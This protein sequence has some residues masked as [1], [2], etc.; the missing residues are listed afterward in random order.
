MGGSGVHVGSGVKV[1]VAVAVEVTVGV[2]VRVGV[3]VGSTTR[4]ELLRTVKTTPAPIAMKMMIN[5]NTS[6]KD[7]VNSG[8]LGVWT[9]LLGLDL[10]AGL[11]SL[12]GNVRP[13]TKHR[14]AFSLSRVPQ[15]GQTRVEE[16]FS[17]L[18]MFSFSFN[19]RVILPHLGF[20]SI[21]SV[22]GML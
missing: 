15:V 10:A 8:I 11:A 9:I 19:R 20:F 6:G 5:P 3:T 17:G 2:T 16:L 21:Y 12:S 13:Q 18:I 7:K 4:P 1:G 22:C 14:V